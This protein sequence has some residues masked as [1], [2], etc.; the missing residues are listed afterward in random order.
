ML[1]VRVKLIIESINAKL[2]AMTR[3]GDLLGGEAWYSELNSAEIL[4]SGKLWV[5]YNYTPVPPLENLVLRQT[6]TDAYLIDFA[7]AVAAA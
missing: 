7:A 1:P 3:E 6:I 2:R 5:S 4:K